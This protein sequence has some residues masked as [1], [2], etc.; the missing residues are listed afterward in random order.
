M[1]YHAKEINEKLSGLQNMGKGSHI[2]SG[3]ADHLSSCDSIIFN[4]LTTSSVWRLPHHH[5]LVGRGERRGPCRGWRSIEGL[6]R[7]DPESRAN[8]KIR[9]NID[10]YVH[11]NVRMDFGFWNSQTSS[12][13]RISIR[14]WTCLWPNHIVLALPDDLSADWTRHLRTVTIDVAN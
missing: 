5:L 7:R 2:S 1:G 4:V 13:S 3:L 12:I 14:F 9:R 8:W 10:I 6:W 11:V